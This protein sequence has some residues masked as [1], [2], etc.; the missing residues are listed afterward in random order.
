VN[1]D[2]TD[3]EFTFLEPI[4][5]EKTALL[6]VGHEAACIFVNDDANARALTVLKEQG[7]KFIALRCAGYNNVIRW[8]LLIM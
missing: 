3:L 1:G 5:N 7:V 4:L 8:I 6:A 2:G